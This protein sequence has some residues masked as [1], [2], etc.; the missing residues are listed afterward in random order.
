MTGHGCETAG[1]NRLAHGFVKKRGDDAAVQVSV[2]AFE[3]V[4]YRG[5][6]N[7]GLVGGQE[8]FQVESMGIGLPTSKAA[9]L[10]SV[11]HRG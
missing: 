9:I 1:A 7:D 10:S 2:R 6:A 5:N 3:C 11:G 4:R 8:K